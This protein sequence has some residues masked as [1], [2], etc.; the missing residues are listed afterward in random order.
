M[1]IDKSWQLANIRVECFSRAVA[2]PGSIDDFAVIF[3]DV[4]LREYL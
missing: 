1:F 4:D 2:R 3:R